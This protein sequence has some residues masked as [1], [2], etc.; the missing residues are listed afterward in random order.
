MIVLVG[1]PGSGKSTLASLMSERHGL[2]LFSEPVE[3]NPYLSL[4]YVDPLSCSFN[5]Q[6]F[7]LHESYKQAVEALK[8]PES[9]MD[10]SIHVNDI[11]SYMQYKT[12]RMS[13]VD[14]ETYTS[15]SRTFHSQLRPPD[16]VVYL[17][18]SPLVS[19]QRIM[20]RGRESE[21]QASIQYWIDINEAY[22]EWYDSYTHSKKICIPVDDLDFVSSTED[23]E[24][25]MNQIL[26]H[27][28]LS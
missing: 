11:F 24:A 3:T 18:C 13:E 10:S 7:L 5:M 4:Y 1:V 19:V 28:H 16:L 17:K 9:I 22:E 14:Y 21:F 12:G 27:L 2:K 6:L 23:Q 25:V 15:V 8:Y 26:E 20:K